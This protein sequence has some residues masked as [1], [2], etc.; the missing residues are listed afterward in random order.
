MLIVYVAIAL[1]AIAV[2]VL[3]AMVGELANRVLTPAERRLGGDHSHS[4]RRHE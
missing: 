2:C 1:L 4:D 3:A